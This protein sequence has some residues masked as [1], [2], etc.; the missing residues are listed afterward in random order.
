MAAL[1]ARDGIGAD[2]VITLFYPCDARSYLFDHP[3]TLMTWDHWN[4]GRNRTQHKG[5]VRMAEAAVGVPYEDLTGLRPFKFEL[6]YR[7]GFPSFPQY[8][9]LDLH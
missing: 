9:S 2:E 3:G 6:F 4:D 8:R 7:T 5:E 1:T